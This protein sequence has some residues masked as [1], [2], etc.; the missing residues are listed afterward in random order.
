MAKQRKQGHP[1]G[2]RP[3]AE[4]PTVSAERAHTQRSRRRRLGGIGFGV[5]LVVLFAFVAIAQ[6]LGAPAVDGSDAALVEDAPDGAVSREEVQAELERTPQTAE[7]EQGS[8]EYDQAVETILDELIL[9]RWFE[10]EAVE[11]G[12]TVSDSEVDDQ[13]ES[14]IE[15][16][17]G[18]QKQFEQFLEQQGFTEDEV[19][20][21]VRLQVLSGK[22]QE[23][24]VPAE[25]EVS[26]D[27]IEA[28][29]DAN[30]DQFTTPES[31]DVRLI[32]AR[33]REQAD[34][35]LAELAD[36]NS[37]AAFERVAKK[38]SSDEATRNSGGLREGVVEGQSEPELD[39]AIFSAPEG[40]L[41]GPVD[42]EQ[43]YYVLQVD[44]IEPESTVSFEEAEPQLRETLVSARRDQLTQLAVTDFFNKWQ[45]R[46]YCA[47]DLR[48]PRCDNASEEDT[49]AQDC[50]QQAALGDPDQELAP[51]CSPPAGSEACTADVIAQV[52][53]STAVPGIVPQ[54]PQEF[55]ATDPAAAATGAA[56]APTAAW[57]AEIATLSQT[58]APGLAQNAWIEPPDPSAQ[59]PGG[60]PPELQQQIPQ[61][62]QVPPQGGAAPVPQGGAAPVPQG[63]APTPSPTP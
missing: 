54:P 15:Q 12:I 44:S 17:L 18:G 48:I 32:L 38:F 55:P 23:E 51:T 63:A 33:D 42:T 30:A 40:E 24:L 22:I 19:R 41:V 11:R 27:E 57:N 2:R 43:G 45:R 49:S 25:P 4:A 47:S 16:Q 26:T 35:A 46:T 39:D 21:R 37:A 28:V 61:G 50:P 59:A 53:C 62:G 60:I 34:A 7:L 10:G 13:L 58:F 8:A 31:R 6:G 52:G 14:T 20:E 1:A 29:Y 9:T 3:K 56:Q 5:L 36:D